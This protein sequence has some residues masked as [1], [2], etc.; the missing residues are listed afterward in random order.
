VL[1][2]S[3]MK[4]L[5]FMAAGNVLHATGTRQISSLGGLARA[6]PRTFALFV[7]GAVAIC[8]LPPLNGFAS[9]LLLYLGLLRAASDGST[10]NWVWASLSAPAL[11]MIGALAV[12]GFVKV[13]GVAFGGAPRSAGA[14]RAHDPSPSMLAPM[15]ALAIGCSMLGLLPNITAPLLSAAVATWDPVLANVAASLT[16]LAPWSPVTAL[17]LASIASAGLLAI[18]LRR[19]MSTPASV[20]T[21]DCG[22]ADATSRMQYGASSF[23][24]T[25]VGLF[26]WVIRSRRSRPEVSGPFPPPSRF[27][28]DVPEPALDLVVLPLTAAADRS[29]ARLRA[30]QR[31][32]VQMYLLYVFG[33]VVILLVVAR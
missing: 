5:L 14:A 32:P 22:Y 9:E 26:D 30:L 3:L 17:S 13:A 24:E 29:L 20:V 8:G 7:V 21:W 31:G 25:L 12:S 16:Q 11:A 4:P 10:Q 27:S 33:A 28:S 6:M 18:V 1:N 23:S 15:L 2:H 19:R